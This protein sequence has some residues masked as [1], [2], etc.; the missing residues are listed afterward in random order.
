MSYQKRE[1]DDTNALLF[2]PVKHPATSHYMEV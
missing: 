1:L 2:N